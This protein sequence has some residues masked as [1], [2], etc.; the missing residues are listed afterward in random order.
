MARP[1]YEKIAETLKK[2]ILNN[3][4]TPDSRLPKITELAAR[5]NVSYVTM[6]NAIRHL[7][8][9]GYITT[10]QGSGIFVNLTLPKTYTDEII[11]L[12]PIEGD[13]YSRCFRAVQDALDDYGCSLTIGISNDRLYSIFEKNEKK[14]FEILKKYSEKSMIIDGTRHFPFSLLKK[15]NPS[16][17]N[18][19]FFMHCDCNE[20]EFPEAVK[21]IPDF[22]KIGQLAAKKLHK[23]GIEKLFL[24]S[25]E[26]LSPEKNRFAGNPAFT[27]EKLILDGMKDY[28]EK[29][30]LGSVSILRGGNYHIDEIEQLTP[31][32]S[33]KCGFMAIGDNRA[34]IIYR[35]AKQHNIKINQDWIIIGLGKTSWC[36]IMEPQLESFSFNEV[37]MMRRLTSEII[38][39]NNSK[40]ILWQ[41]K[42]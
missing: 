11:Y 16:G 5:F 29:N 8:D 36:D 23:K 30:S 1:K 35:Y 42:I 20:D 41:P 10:V 9:M 18:I 24:L 32:H 26:E 6:S 22:Y 37:T 4:F 33:K 34:H 3:V 28:A 14:A 21:I 12:A 15:I 2:D 25:Y 38:N 31:Y 27:Y 7:T 39:K 40:Y 13:L 17:K 19:F